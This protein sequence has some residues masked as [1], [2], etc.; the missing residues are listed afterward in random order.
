[1]AQSNRERVQKGLDVLQEEL[2]GFVE[3][4]MRA[5]FGDRWEEIAR[6]AVDGTVG[7]DFF[8]DVAALLNVMTRNWNQTFGPVL[9]R[10]VRPLVEE[11]KGVRVRWAHQEAFSTENAYR[12]LDSMHR[13]LEAISSEQLEE[14]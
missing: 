5:R 1:M 12:A 4:E 2:H 9:G 3:R 10:Q 8:W 13:L 14:I 7:P 6:S 11:L